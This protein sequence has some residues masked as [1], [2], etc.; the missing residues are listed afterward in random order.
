MNSD[1]YE[2]AAVEGKDPGLSTGM[3]PGQS[4]RALIR[5]TTNASRRI[6]AND[7]V[8]ASG[9]IFGSGTGVD[10]YEVRFYSGKPA[11]RM[12]STSGSASTAF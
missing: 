10:L 7:Q 9:L 8:S 11:F 12:P 5:E 6:R 4:A 2:G 1:E 3:S